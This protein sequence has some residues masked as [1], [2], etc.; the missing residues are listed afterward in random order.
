[1][2]YLLL[3]FQFD[4]RY[5]SKTNMETDNGTFAYVLRIAYRMCRCYVS[6][7]VHVLIYMHYTKSLAESG[8]IH[9]ALF[10]AQRIL[11]QVW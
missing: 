2:G 6:G 3:C 5:P 1:M 4:T 9:M 11:L 8:F 10:W 7:C